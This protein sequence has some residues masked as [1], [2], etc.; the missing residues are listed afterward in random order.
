MASHITNSNNTTDNSRTYRDA[1]HNEFSRSI[2]HGNVIIGA[3]TNLLSTTEAGVVTVAKRLFL[4]PFRENTAFVGR[5]TTFEQL[6]KLLCPEPEGQRRAALWGL[7]GIGKT[8]VAIE[9]C[10][11][12][13][14]AHPQEHIFWIHGNSEQTFKAGY[15]EIR[16]KAS[17]I[18][19]GDNEE[20][21]LDG[22]KSWLESSQ[23]RDW[24][25]VI[26]NFDDIDLK[27]QK[28]I[29]VE[30]GTILFTTRDKRL[31]GHEGYLSP[32]E[33]VELAAM[34]DQEA[35]ETF[36]KLLG[37]SVETHPEVCMQLLSLFEN[38]P[39]AIAQAAAYIRETNTEIP[40]YLK[41]FKEYEPTERNLLNEA[42]PAMGDNSEERAVMTTWK[43]TV[44]RI[45]QTS[46]DSVRLLELLSFLGPDDIPQE[47]INGLPLI[48]NDLFLL[49]KSIRPLL[50]F[51]LLYCL[52]A[53]NYR[54]HRL[55]ASS[56]RAEMEPEVR[57]EHL[58]TV[59]QFMLENMPKD[60]LGNMSKCT[61]LLPHA[62]A[63]LEHT[64]VGH[65]NPDFKMHWDLQHKVG[66]ALDYTGAYSDALKWY[67]RAL[68]G[69]EKTLGKDHPSTLDTVHNMACVFASKGEYGK[70]LEWYQ[71]ALDGREKTLG[72]DH[73]S[74]LATVHNMASV[75]NDQGEYGKALQWYQRAL[76]GQEKTLGKDQFYTLATVH[77]IALLFEKQHDHDKALQWYQRALDGREKTLGK[78]HPSTLDTVHNMASVFVNQRDHDKALQWYQRALDGREKILGKDHRSTLN[79]VHNMACVF[80]GKGEYDKVLEWY[81]RALDGYE[82][83]LGNDHPSTLTTVYNMA[84]VFNQQGEYGK[85]LQWY[86]RALDGY[87]KMLG[88]DHPS[89]LTTVYNMASVFNQQG[90]YGKALQWYQRALDGQ[91]K[92]LGKDQSSVLDTVHNM[93]SVFGDQGE[94]GKALQW[95][96]R[97]LDGREKTLG[98]DHPSTLATVH[99]IA[100]VF[101]NQDEYGKALQWYQRALDGQEKTLGKDHPSTLATVHNMASMFNN[102]GE[103]GQALQWYQRALDGREKT[104]GKDHPSTLAT[105]H[106]IASVLY[107]QSEYGKALQWYQRA[108][109]GRENT[110]GKDHP[111]TL[112]TAN[113]MAIVSGKQGEYVNGKKLKWYQ[114]AL[115]WL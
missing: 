17:L 95:Y 14:K 48:K 73:P 13:K 107:N 57:E 38:L 60:P 68:D 66:S 92:M 62:V 90:E 45:Q 7:G 54:I 6:E 113:N 101:Y 58:E 56:I 67:Q 22:V 32:N 9:F 30:R 19:T 87:E 43:I 3:S 112:A 41:L 34:S 1:N 52:R 110:L 42:L 104:L 49:K 25:M 15:L 80:K 86:Q 85:A 115:R 82:K 53:S 105:V 100:S 27:V 40:E 23:S 35:F 21:R 75:F 24:V 37:N 55:V 20:E 74:T 103:Y 10:Y 69:Y 61:R 36:T 76:D 99:N 93:A 44:D 59:V 79:T 97:A 77:N 51:A 2:I 18:V 64:P 108:L 11:R 28:Y 91:E 4:V 114:G 8:T 84:S 33:G 63:V 5:E 106:N 89:T 81:Q 46:P 47:L 94:Y 111:S 102:Q 16:R 26:D 39:L 88:N 50:S 65:R 70:V 98:K 72:N 71:R 83:M 109:D 96:K 29:P 12:R 31:I 78:D